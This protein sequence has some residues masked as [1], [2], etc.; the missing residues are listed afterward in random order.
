MI[1]P[2][3][4]LPVSR[5]Y[6]QLFENVGV[7]CL[8]IRFYWQ[9]RFHSFVQQPTMF[10]WKTRFRSYVQQPTMFSQS[11]NWGTVFNYYFQL[12]RFA[13]VC[14]RMLSLLVFIWLLKGSR[15]SSAI[16]FLENFLIQ[17][18]DHIIYLRIRAHFQWIQVCKHRCGI[19]WYCYK[20]HFDCNYVTVQHTRLCLKKWNK[21]Q[22]SINS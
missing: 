10:S 13:S 19:H 17:S 9:T 18:V 15:R 22:Q 12:H 4:N 11:K 7:N 21:Q 14:L 20:L 1:R 3:R 8:S 16:P 2:T 6:M 5:Q